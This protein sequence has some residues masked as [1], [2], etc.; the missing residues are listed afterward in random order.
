MFDPA[1]RVCR[2]RRIALGERNSQ[3]N[4]R[5]AG[6]GA[7]KSDA[8]VAAAGC[9]R[10]AAVKCLRDDLEQVYRLYH[11]ALALWLPF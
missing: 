11:V 2:K 5:R 4:A 7:T 10:G 6:I 8:P 3:K 1:A 9:F